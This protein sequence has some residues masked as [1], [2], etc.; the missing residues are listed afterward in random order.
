MSLIQ[1]CELNRV[2]LLDY[3]TELQGHAEDLRKD[4]TA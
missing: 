4:P 1:T 2:N 3:M